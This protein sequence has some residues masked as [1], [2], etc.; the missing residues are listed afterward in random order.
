MENIKR[1][2]ED[3]AKKSDFLRGLARKGDKKD[4]H[5]KGLQKVPLRGGRFWCLR[6]MNG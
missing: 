2:G 5:G 4:L 6:W 3:F 1:K